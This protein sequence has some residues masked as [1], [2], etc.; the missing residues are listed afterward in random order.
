MSDPVV[1]PMGVTPSGLPYPEDSDQVLMGAQAIKALAQA[2]ETQR[3]VGQPSGVFD[4]LAVLGAT[5][6][7]IAYNMDPTLTAQGSTVPNTNGRLAMFAVMVSK[8]RT[9]TGMGMYCDTA[10]T[11]MGA[12][13]TYN[14][15]GL[16]QYAA[17]GS[18]TFL[19]DTGASDGSIFTSA[20]TVNLRPWNQGPIQL[21]PNIVYAAGFTQ[22]QSAGTN[23]SM[24]GL[25]GATPNGTIPANSPFQRA[26]G[27]AAPGGTRA[28][29]MKTWPVGSFVQYGNM[30]IVMLY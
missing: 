18:C 30:P 5:T 16:W 17:D 21:L 26:F 10:G 20:P 12:A 4:A 14:G 6:P 23:A 2:V 22:Q 28:L 8:A 11:G 7:P 1:M 3:P 27:V 25:Q 24:R 15:Y 19:R 29:V 9:C 13:G